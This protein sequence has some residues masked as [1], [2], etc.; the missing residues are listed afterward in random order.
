[1]GVDLA[2]DAWLGAHWLHWLL[3]LSVALLSAAGAI[4]LWSR[5]RAAHRA[6]SGL[7][8]DLAA[9][10][11]D[12]E[13]WRHEAETALRG[14]GAAIDRQLDHWKLSVAERE[15]AL[16]LLKGHDVAGGTDAAAAIHWTAASSVLLLTI[17]RLARVLWR[18]TSRSSPARL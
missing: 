14:L 4:A 17:H 7:S 5:M 9:S 1:M 15:I 3:E 8:R 11:A 6:A 16:L 2:T 13:R 18:P 10:R 12:A